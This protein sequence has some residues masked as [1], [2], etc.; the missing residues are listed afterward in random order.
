M[1][2]APAPDRRGTREAKP[3]IAFSQQTWGVH[4]IPV[5]MRRFGNVSNHNSEETV[6]G[7]GEG[8]GGGDGG[9]RGEL[10]L[11]GGSG[12]FEDVYLRRQ[13]G[14]ANDRTVPVVCGWSCGFRVTVHQ[15]LLQIERCRNPGIG[16]N[17]SDIFAL[18]A[19]L[20]PVRPWRPFL[21]AC[22]A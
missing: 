22:T 1:R 5:M 14:S 11:V 16:C 17:T 21:P 9:A 13:A 20:P 6:K 18:S 3:R 19:K 10:S 2:R 12:L 8:S 4:V 15:A 7:K